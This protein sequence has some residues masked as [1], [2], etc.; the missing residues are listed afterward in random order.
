MFLIENDSDL[1]TE[2]GFLKDDINDLR[3]EYKIISIEENED[4]L[5]Y[6][7][8]QEESIIEKFLNK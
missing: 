1:L 4:H 7:R 8:D 2:S 5:P 3:R 6:I